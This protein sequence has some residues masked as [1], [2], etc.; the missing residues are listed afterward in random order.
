MAGAA[1]R[2]AGIE[3]GRLVA[4]E[5]VGGGCINDCARLRT[6]AG[7]FFLKWN[8]D[9]DEAFF[10]VEAEGLQALAGTRTVRAPGVVARS[11][12]RD[13]VHWLLLEWIE[14]SDAAG[15][16]WARLGRELA[17]LHA[18]GRATASNG[19]VP[20]YGWPSGNLIGPLPQPNPPSPNWPCF[21]VRNRI[22]PLAGELHAAGKLSA[23]QGK[24]LDEAAGAMLSLLEPA[25]AEGPSLL[26]GDLW[27]GN[28][29]FAGRGEPVVVDPAVYKGHRE[30]DLAMASLFG[31]FPPAFYEAY[32]ESWP[33]AP[34]HEDR[35]PAYQLY[36][37]LVHARLFGGGY[38]AQALGAAKHVLARAR[39]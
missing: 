28:V 39:P 8:A 37:L 35:R 11:S 26:H 6:R 22:R 7:C 31:G 2:A 3:P 34:G 9:A 36:P 21:W 27:S 18:H 17:A 25:G 38:L 29:L 23:R 32:H 16:D 15:P 33:L 10:R 12:E 30:V 5:R 4:V 13:G 19:P 1:L 14:P 20:A 24:L